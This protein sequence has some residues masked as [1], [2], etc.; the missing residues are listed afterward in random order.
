MVKTLGLDLGTS[1]LGWAIVERDNNDNITLLDHGVDIFQE[2][3]AREKNVESPAVQPRTEAR[4]SRRHYFRRRLRKIEVLKVLVRH[5]LCPTLSDEQLEQWRYKRLYPLSDD[6]I[7]WQRTDEKSG[8]N[9]YY[10]RYR[11]L[12]EVLDLGVQA[13][14]HALGRALYH[15]SQRRGF[16]SNRKD[17]SNSE[18]GVVKQHIKELNEQVA[19]AGCSYLGEYFYHCYRNG[20]KIRTRYTSR[21]EHLRAEL[22]A[23]CRKQQLSPE[24]QRALARAILFQRPLKSQKGSV[25]KCTFEKGKSRCPVSHPRFEEFRMLQFVNNIRITDVFGEERALSPEE[26]EKIRPLFFRKS[27]THFDF[28]EI[29]KRIAGKGNYAC[30]DYAS[31]VAYRFNYPAATTVSGCPVTAKLREIFGDDY[32]DAVCEVYTLGAGKSPSEIENDVWHALFSFDDEERLRQWAQEKLQLSESEAG[33]FADIHLQQGYASLCLNAIDKMLPLLRRGFRYDEA[34]FLANLRVVLPSEVYDDEEHRCR[35]EEDLSEI[36]RNYKRNEYDKYDSKE[37]RIKEYFV[38]NGID[39]SRLDRLYH[40][41]MIETYKRAELGKR[42]YLQL[43]SPRTSSVRNP[44]AM[45]A[46][47]RLRALV[48]ALLRDGKIDSGTKINIEFARG[49]NDANRRKAIE[50][51]QRDRDKEHQAYAAELKTLYREETGLDIEPSQTDVLKYRLSKEQKG[52]CP[53]TGKQMRVSD[54][55]GPNTRF[56]IEHT[57]PRSREGDDSQMNKTLCDSFF[58]RSVKKGKLPA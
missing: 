48:N 45:R 53:Y 37:W 24:L 41:S 5:D 13:D 3:V 22:E 33:K 23:I 4:A 58:N 34:V 19:A 16:L 26:R 51:Y 38:Y 25:G 17:A 10:D 28:E 12:T 29:A 1:S 21:N 32:L 15:L 39:T 50:Q 20:I 6:F 44:M 46:L 35:V 55:I 27:K 14:R 2:G 43:G 30:K 57:V 9:P 54:F 7:R 31:K 36:V 18:E 8:K 52:I 42:G 47:F 49:L 40:P 11:A 56:D